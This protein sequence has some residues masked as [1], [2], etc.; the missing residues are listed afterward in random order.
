MFILNQCLLI[1]CILTTGYFY[2]CMCVRADSPEEAQKWQP[3]KCDVCKY[4]VEELKLR[5]G[6]TNKKE[7]IRIGHGLDPDHSIDY[8]TS[9][10]RLIEALQ[11][12][13]VCDRL[14]KYDIHKE[15]KGSLRFAK[16]KSETMQ[17]LQ[18]LVN[19]GVKVDM[20]IPYDLWNETSAEV[21]ELHRMCFNMVGDYED[22]I[23]E[24]Y[25]HH[26][27]HDLLDYLCEKRILKHAK[28]DSA[29]L[30]EVYDEKEAKRQRE[31]DE[32]KKA[33]QASESVPST[34]KEEL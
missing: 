18:G 4:L 6:E 24:W 12:P 15:R 32:K 8:Q 5:L 13:H 23:E 26:Q 34:D 29:C 7:K 2:V 17:T 11:D 21:R 16:G 3:G 19:R 28:V 27:N 14:L 31:E 1:V 30:Y 9:E 25:Y 33:A 10:L 20:D 22:D